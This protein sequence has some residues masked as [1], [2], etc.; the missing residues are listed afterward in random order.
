VRI[1]LHCHSTHSDGSFSAAQVAERAL[2]RDVRL[3]CL[4]DHDNCDGFEATRSA[5]DRALQGVEL[6][7]TLDNRSVH[8]LVY[9]RPSSTTWPLMLTALEEQKAARRRRVHL[10]AEKLAPLGAKFDPGALVEKYVGTT[11]G[12]PHIA[13]ELVRVGAVSSRNEAFDRYLH[14]GGPGDVQASRLSLAD[15]LA[16]GLAAGGCMSL[17]HPHV[18]GKR[19]EDMLREYKPM[20]L[21]GLEVFYGQYK[22][23]S[24]KG[25]AALAEELDLV[26]T[27]GSDF[28]GE[29]VPQVPRL[30]V[31]VPDSVAQT[32]F[33]WL[34][35]DYA[36]TTSE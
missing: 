7:C 30:G 8:V 19:T 33:E 5:F 35:V 21:S 6:S 32:I 29:G 3:F 28:H 1:D 12:R 31:D 14:D 24:R 2:A 27:G 26:Q 11:I 23:K 15:G 13:D 4:T 17:A 36:P 10:I 16:M 34:E 20:G 9:Q 25:W 18:H 22:S